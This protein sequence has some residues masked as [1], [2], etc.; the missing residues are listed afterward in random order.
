MRAHYT[1][2]GIIRCLVMQHF[3]CD[4]PV[5]ACS[6]KIFSYHTRWPLYNGWA[7]N[8]SSFK[9]PIKVFNW[10]FCSTFPM[11]QGM[12]IWGGTDRWTRLMCRV[13]SRKCMYGLG[14]PQNTSVHLYCCYVS[15]AVGVRFRTVCSWVQKPWCCSPWKMV[16]TGAHLMS[17][18]LTESG[19]CYDLSDIF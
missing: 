10:S 6:R 19:R 7:H 3:K 8:L 11:L 17:I 1:R 18:C 9:A 13:P 2:A 4:N 16:F 14:M 15:V 12:K 5:K